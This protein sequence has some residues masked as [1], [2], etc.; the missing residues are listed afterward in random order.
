MIGTA[1]DGA[2]CAKAGASVPPIK[3]AAHGPMSRAQRHWFRNR[4]FFMVAP[5]LEVLAVVSESIRKLQNQLGGR[6]GRI[7][8][9]QKFIIAFE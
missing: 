8:G 2:L 3:S 7:A 4:K 5:C 6:L 9:M 1:V